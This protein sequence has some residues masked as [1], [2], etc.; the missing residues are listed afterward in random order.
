MRNNVFAFNLFLF[1]T[2]GI[3]FSA[4]SSQPKNPGDISELRRRAESQLDQGNRQADRGS[5][6][7]AL[8]L[9]DEAMRLAVAVDDPGLLIRV[10]LSRSN[11]L[12]TLGN[13]EESNNGW[14]KA[15]AEAERIKDG[16]LTAA[17][18]IHM[19]RGK[20]LLS[21]GQADIAQ[22]VRDDVSR[23]LA[24][25]KS[26]RLYIAF[27]WTV[28]GLAEKELG[29]YQAAEAAV[30]RSLDI[31]VKDVYFELAAYDWFLIASFRSLSGNLIGARQALESALSY[32]R[33]VENSWGL[34]CDWRAFGDVY[35]KE[36]DRDAART[37]YLRAADIFRA[38]GN[39]EA[40]E[41]TLS[42]ID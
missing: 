4:C 30:R 25:V 2:L 41:G 1:I 27:A 13:K 38:M 20:L 14:L 42:R 15:L 19:A 5:L 21:P 28:T 7:D 32:D 33:R 10:G 12:F 9:L 11:V 23:D 3:I 16:E 24:M 34:A 6:E 18:R 39:D 26:E 40:A 37:A 17:S 31:H 22:S 35:K 29:N 36:G 8:V